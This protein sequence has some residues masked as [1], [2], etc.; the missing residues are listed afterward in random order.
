MT[1]KARIIELTTKPWVMA[2]TIM[3]SILGVV[4]L[5]GAVGFIAAM[6]T[7]W[8]TIVAVFASSIAPNVSWI[9][10]RPATG[11]LVGVGVV[12]VLARADRVIDQLRDKYT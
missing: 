10:T 4:G 2:T 8:F 1:W 6:G 11:L 5:K 9:P 12:F 3:G 7:K